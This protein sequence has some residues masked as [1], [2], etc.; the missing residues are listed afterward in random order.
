[1]APR[2]PVPNREDSNTSLQSRPAAQQ[3]EARP[4]NLAG[5]IAGALASG[6]LV[7]ML[8]ASHA[9]LIFSPRQPDLYAIGFQMAV[10]SSIVLSAVIALFSSIR[11]AI[12]FTQ[13]TT[14]LS[15]SVLC[16]AVLAALPAGIGQAEQLS[17]LLA[18]ILSAT[19]A[20]G[21]F[22]YLMGRFKLGRLI[23][24][25]P[26]PVIG[27]FLAATGCLIVKG[28]FGLVWT[29]PGVLDSL[30]QFGGA[31]QLF[32]P[33]AAICLAAV[34]FVAARRSASPYVVPVLVLACVAV[35]HLVRLL[36]GFTVGD[37]AA[38]G[39]LAGEIP[40][41]AVQP[42]FM[43][44]DPQA[45]EWTLLM[46]QFPLILTV[47]A[48]GTIALLMSSSAMELSLDNEIDLDRELRA[49]GAGSILSCLGGGLPGYVSL[50]C[51][52]L[53]RQLGGRARAGGLIVAAMGIG[54]L[55]MGAGALQIIPLPVLAGLLIWVGSCLVY[56]WLYRSWSRVSLAEYLVL[57]V[58]VLVVVFVGMLE[59]VFTGLI[60]G[61]ALFVIDYSRIEVIK[62]QLTARHFNSRR[63]MP[64][65]W[66]DM[67]RRHGGEIVILKLQGFIFFGTAHQLVERIRTRLESQDQARVRYLVMDF[68]HTNGIDSSAVLSFIKLERMAK[69][70]R[71]KVVL[72]SLDD[73]TFATLKRGGFARDET[74]NARFFDTLDTGLQWCEDKL[75]AK[76]A[77]DLGE[78]SR[79]PIQ[80]RL[81]DGDGSSA[82]AERMLSHMGRYNIEAGTVLI[83][84]GSASRDMYFVESGQFSV[85]IDRGDG[86]DLRIS[87]LLPGA[88]IGEVAFYMGRERSASVVCDEAGCVWRLSR[89]GLE[90]MKQADP[91]AANYLNERMSYML[92]ER[93]IGTTRLVQHLA[94]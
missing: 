93:L 89:D 9:S 57:L 68:R 78:I 63:V 43:R 94:D 14:S 11:G 50:S 90:R 33:L 31:E 80:E 42:A 5:T 73:D 75:I 34:L 69:E 6:A 10:M 46:R 61:V 91:E 59:G 49:A 21:L 28:G 71:C 60:A 3:T 29:G 74:S 48:V 13:D 2:R 55:A 51:T 88:V 12:A 15:I 25:T 8:T 4:L 56:D 72:T 30:A 84:Q 82:M 83:E 62:T 45:V 81:F 20:A 16:V 85:M 87:T 58:I 77:P 23:R 40:A 54:V 32:K 41:Q 53:N 92:A 70:F 22:F 52:M 65:A 47:L 24:F 64:D 36:Y 76:V 26:I 44:I 19:F 17:T 7:I 27:G 79:V 18:G 66:R 86:A 39:W 35:F 37:L 1:M 38:S 67:M